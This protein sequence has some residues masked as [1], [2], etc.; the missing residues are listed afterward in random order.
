MLQLFQ[1]QLSRGGPLTITHPGCRRYFMTIPEAVEL[2]LQA[3][4]MGRGGEIFVLEMGDPV[5]IVD[6]AKNLVQLSGLTPEQDIQFVYTGLRPGEKLFEEL[7]LDGEGVKVTSHEKI[8]VL[9]G[10]RVE[11]SSVEHWLEELSA[12]VDMKNVYGLITKLQTIVPEYTPSAELLGLCKLDRHDLFSEY[13]RARME[14]FHAATPETPAAMS[15][16]NAA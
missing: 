9:D 6:L 15:G 12:V 5:N 11:F 3:S 2:V 16:S 13:K 4:T 1:Q 14:L 8:R 10:G 7:R